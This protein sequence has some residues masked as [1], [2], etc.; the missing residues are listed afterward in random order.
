MSEADLLPVA[1]RERVTHLFNQTAVER[2]AGL[3]LHGLCAA[4]AARTPDAPAVLFRDIVLTH[5]EVDLQARRL[6]ASLRQHHGVSPGDL[7]GVTV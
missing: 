3:T 6:A 5:G 2:P 4:Q 1:A 7:V